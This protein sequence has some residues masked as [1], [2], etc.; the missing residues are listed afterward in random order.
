MDLMKNLSFTSVLLRLVFI[1]G[2]TVFSVYELNGVD[3]NTPL[4]ELALFTFQISILF[5]AGV[6]SKGTI[7]TRLVF[8]NG[9]AYAFSHYVLLAGSHYFYGQPYALIWLPVLSL[10]F[11]YLIFFYLTF[12]QCKLLNV[13]E[14]WGVPDS[15]ADS[16]VGKN[17]VTNMQFYFIQYWSIMVVIDFVWGAGLLLFGLYHGVPMIDGSIS[18]TMGY[19][20]FDLYDGVYFF[21][22]Y[23]VD[24]V[25]TIVLFRKVLIDIKRPDALGIGQSMMWDKT[26]A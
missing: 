8:F 22:L 14:A 21:S 15:V 6:F 10:S 26:K 1:G 25:M 23:C 5:F 18:G 4:H 13:F 12:V 17:G 11:G 3:W 2:I 7:N 16:I 20:L 24:L 9:V 19:E